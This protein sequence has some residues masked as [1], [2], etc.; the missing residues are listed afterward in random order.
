MMIGLVV[1]TTRSAAP[2]YAAHS[3]FR[4]AQVDIFGLFDRLRQRGVDGDGTADLTTGYLGGVLS[5][6]SIHPTRTGNGL[7]ANAFIDSIDQRFGGTLPDV[8]IARVARRDPLVDNRF[9]PAG[10]PPFGLIGD[11]DTNN[12]AGF[13][14]DVANRISNGAQH[15]GNDTAGAGKDLFRRRKRFFKNLF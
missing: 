5:L 9:R 6:D 11:D 8:D 2:S 1:A 15:I 3:R 12:L 14:T 4:R 10:E 7:I 13:F